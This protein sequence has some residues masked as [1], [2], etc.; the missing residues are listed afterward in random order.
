MQQPERKSAPFCAASLRCALAGFAF[1]GTEMILMLIGYLGWL[2]REW[3]GLVYLAMYASALGL[4]G[5][6]LAGPVLSVVS[7]I[8]REGRARAALLCLVLNL[9]PFLLLQLVGYFVAWMLSG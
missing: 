9:C 3:F 8:R 5:C 6:L 2:P 4:L 1:F 7:L